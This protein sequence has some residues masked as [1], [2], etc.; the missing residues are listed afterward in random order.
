MSAN[1]N[2]DYYNPLALSEHLLSWPPSSDV[3]SR[4]SP[5]DNSAERESRLPKELQGLGI[6]ELEEDFTGL[7]PPYDLSIPPNTKIRSG[8]SC[9]VYPIRNPDID[10]NIDPV[11][12]HFGLRPDPFLACKRVD[13]DEDGSSNVIKS[14]TLL[15]KAF[16]GHWGCTIELR[17]VYYVP[18]KSRGTVYLVLAPWLE[19]SLD[20]FLVYLIGKRSVA[21]TE[22][23]NI[24]SWYK[25]DEFQHWPQFILDC[26]LFL[27]GLANEH[28]TLSGDDSRIR[29]RDLKPENILLQPG[30]VPESPDFRIR[31]YFIDFGL[32]EYFYG[33]PAR[34]SHTGTNAYL[35]PEQRGDNPPNFTTDVW[36][37]GC[38]FA[39]IEGLLHSGREGV[40][41]IFE[42]ALEGDKE[43]RDHI[44]EVNEFLDRLPTQ[45]LPDALE[46]FRTSLRVMVREHMLVELA[47][48]SDAL[49]LQEVWL[50]M[51]VKYKDSR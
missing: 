31:P 51:I 2:D 48:R 49:K 9:I 20:T 46:V 17:A 1:R 23:S 43:F 4:E 10:T 27:A 13:L 3:D 30:W 26:S 40:L 24:N 47:H 39:L 32:G 5:M 14:E 35:A 29:H 50:P 21:E 6:I 8:S 38:C 33:I 28:L 25:E 44:K 16:K 34:S 7:A 45:I 42:I 22:L 37:L 12:R 18:S 15:L 36:S 41:R 19:L 11:D